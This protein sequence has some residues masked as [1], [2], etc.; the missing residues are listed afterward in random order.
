MSGAGLAPLV[1]VEPAAVEGAFLTP[2]VQRLMTSH[3]AFA[4]HDVQH[5]GNER[6]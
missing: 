6:C 3:G 2:M 1:V 4:I 5:C